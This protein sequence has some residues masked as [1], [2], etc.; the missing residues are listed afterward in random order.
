MAAKETDQFNS[1]PTTFIEVAGTSL[2]AALDVARKFGCVTDSVL[3]FAPPHLYQGSPREFYA[4]A[5]KLRVESYTNLGRNTQSWKEWLANNGPILTRLDVDQTWYEA[6]DNN[7]NLDHYYPPIQ[8]AGHAI[9]LVGYLGDRFI[10]RN[11]WGT[12]WGDQGFAYA[13]TE[14]A[15]D[16]FTEAYGVSVAG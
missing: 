15:R 8:P 16:A 12:S 2:K 9:A 11:S 1:R 6:A 7:G 5:S 3:P 13:S 10:V 14:Y 4:L